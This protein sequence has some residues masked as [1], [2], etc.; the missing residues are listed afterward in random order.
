LV[1]VVVSSLYDENFK[2]TESGKNSII[3]I[4][5]FIT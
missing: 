4:H 1:F 3:N 5:V 2:C